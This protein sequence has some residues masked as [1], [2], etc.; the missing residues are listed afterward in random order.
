[1][2]RAEVEW[3]DAYSSWVLIALSGALPRLMTML[4]HARDL[5]GKNKADR[6]KAE[7]E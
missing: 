2:Q 7:E 1:M 5:W 4:R 3:K 6:Y